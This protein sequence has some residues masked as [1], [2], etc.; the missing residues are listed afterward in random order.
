MF[1]LDCCYHVLW[2][3]LCLLVLLVFVMVFPLLCVIVLNVLLV[4]DGVASFC[5]LLLVSR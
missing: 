4:L 2:F 1:V 3:C 5:L